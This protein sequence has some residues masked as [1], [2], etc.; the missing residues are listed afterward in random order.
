MTNFDAN[1]TE[2]LL[3][4]LSRM[5][6]LPGGMSF[7]DYNDL[8]ILFARDFQPELY[9]KL[10]HRVS[11]REY[12]H[13]LKAI[14]LNTPPQMAG[15]IILGR[16]ASGTSRMHS[17]DATT[18][19]LGIGSTGS[20]KSV[21]LD[22]LILQFLDF[23][24]GLFLFDF[25]KREMRGIKRQAERLGH[26]VHICRHEWLQI[27]ILDPEE[28]DPSLNAN[29]CSEF[30][31]ITL[32]L[33]PVA[34]HILKICIVRLYE[35]F[36]LFN[37]PKASPP[38][39]S[40][41]I[42]E[43]KYFEGN[44]S[45]KDAILIR[46]TALL[47]NKS[48]VFN[49]RRGFQIKDLARKFIV[50]ELDGIETQYQDLIA[51]HLLGKLFAHRVTHPSSGLV[52]AAIDEASHVFSKQAESTN[53]GTTF[54]D[55]MVSVVRQ[56]RICIFAFTQTLFG[57]ANSIIVNSGTKILFP[58]G[59]SYDYDI[60]G[61]AIAMTAEQRE[62]AKIHLRPGIQIIK[63]TGMGWLEPFVNYSPFIHIPEDVS[64][65]E[66]RESFLP[67]L[68]LIPKPPAVLL[69]PAFEAQTTNT[70][71]KES[72]SADEEIL[73]NQIKA[74]P[75]ITSATVHYQMSGLG[76]K[77]GTAAKQSLLFKNLIK[78]T[79]L[80]SGRRGRAEIFL[81]LVKTGTG[82]FGSTV[83]KHM[84][85]KADNWYSRQTC[86]TEPEKSFNLNGQQIFVDLAVTWP[87][88]RSE[89]VEMETQDSE[90][91][92][93]NIKKNLALGFAVIS[94]L[95]PNRKVRD[96]IKRRA[97]SELTTADLSRIK[98]PVMSFYDR[99]LD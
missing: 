19:L 80:E 27:N 4:L 65:G 30:L 35:R 11:F 68:D 99:P 14:P 41:L 77:C 2:L 44:K 1:P 45:A 32:G 17:D 29:L 66:A 21:F 12:C 96:A 94:V 26:K 39:L 98:F 37:N 60:F 15:N 91:A 71:S 97:N 83:H 85:K 31:T 13:S 95:T 73:L 42:S 9:T 87:D 3:Q 61:K 59:S 36:G 75:G 54:I 74:N 49:V 51:S 89:A 81:E 25:V 55:T 90:R 64:D 76:T 52:I 78:E 86:V 63:K 82:R 20:G 22:F 67:L 70:S 7:N 79:L 24:E 57:L 56:K 23:I 69:L 84:R 8:R 46:L 47:V 34:K 16:N 6:K 93:E 43:V 28:I 18:H 62:W 72:L 48:Q 92:I 5:S 33:P 50:F 40:D 58:A 88:G 10:L 38:M 53:Q